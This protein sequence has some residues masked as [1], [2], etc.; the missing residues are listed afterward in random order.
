MTVV[1]C[2]MLLWKAYDESKS[3]AENTGSSVWHLEVYRF[4]VCGVGP[5]S[6]HRIPY[7]LPTAAGTNRIAKISMNQAGPGK[8]PRREQSRTPDSELEGAFPCCSGRI[9]Y[10]QQPGKRI[11]A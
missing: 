8:V 10:H 6:L 7:G 9:T 3:L 11:P 1:Q 5:W 2:S 4:E